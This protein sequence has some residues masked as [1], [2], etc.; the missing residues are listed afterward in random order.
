LV[1]IHL[2]LDSKSAEV[3][4]KANAVVATA[5]IANPMLTNQIIREALA[6]FL[7]RGLRTQQSTSGDDIPVPW[8]KHAKLS[9]LLLSATSFAK[10]TETFI[11][12]KS[13][14][15]LIVLVHHRLIC[16]CLISRE[17]S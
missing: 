3:Q 11:K 13:V 4:R 1:L 17:M 8:N 15:E 5:T 9:G 12:E 10:E 14:V 16:P 2:A 6:R 7:A